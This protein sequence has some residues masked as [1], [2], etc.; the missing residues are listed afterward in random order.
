MLL[1]VEMME[2]E[3]CKMGKHELCDIKSCECGCHSELAR[4]PSERIQEDRAYREG[5]PSAN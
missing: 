5:I 4:P 2:S 1:I 3:S